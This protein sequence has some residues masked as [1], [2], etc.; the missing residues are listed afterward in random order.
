VFWPEQLFMNTVASVVVFATLVAL[1]LRE[2]GANLDAPAEPSSAEY[3]ARPEWYFLSLVQLLKYF[4]GKQE[5]IGTI[6]IPSAILVVMLLVPLFDRMLPCGLAH[7]LA[8]GVVFGLVGGA[9]YLTYEAL[10]TDANDRHFQEAQHK[11]DAAGQRALQLAGLG[12]PPDG[13]MY[14]L[15]RDPLTHGRAVLE[16]KCLGC[17]YYSGKHAGKQTV[18]DLKDF[19]SYAWIR[20]LLEN[21][22]STGHFG[23][24]A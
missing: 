18:S 8:C 6:V 13:P 17:H 11:A 2:G 14:L 16:Q 9:G 7:F 5:T 1:V 12:V 22:K 24:V 4:P 19:G 3:P 10:K 21:P 20:G 15:L 23:V